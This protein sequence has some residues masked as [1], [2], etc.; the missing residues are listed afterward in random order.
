MIVS[1]PSVSIMKN[2]KY[3]K[4]GGCF[5][6]SDIVDL[7]LMHLGVINGNEAS[8]LRGFLF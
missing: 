2:T 4:K 1:H 3:M 6:P 7:F 8:L 5:V